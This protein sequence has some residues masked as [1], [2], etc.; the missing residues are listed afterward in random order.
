MTGR[1]PAGIYPSPLGYIHPRWDISIPA[2]IYLIPVGYIYS[3]FNISNP[4]G[5]YA[6]RA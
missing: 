5:I 1:N 4:A 6:I 3:R 2:G